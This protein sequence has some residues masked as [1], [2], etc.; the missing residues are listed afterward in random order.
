MT[1]ATDL[2]PAGSMLAVVTAGMAARHPIR[3]IALDTARHEVT[4][5][6]DE[7]DHLQLW[8]NHLTGCGAVHHVCDVDHGRALWTHTCRLTWQGWQVDLRHDQV[9]PPATAPTS[10]VL[11]AA[12]PEV[13]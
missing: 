3:A 1:T 7:L 2:A 9:R 8:R 6:V 11:A 5:A 13:A 10:T 4:I 12:L